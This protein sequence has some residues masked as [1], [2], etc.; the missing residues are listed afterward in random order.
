ME[1]HRASH[2]VN[3]YALRDINLVIELRSR[4]KSRGFLNEWV[5]CWVS[6]GIRAT[7]QLLPQALDPVRMTMGSEGVMA[8]I[9]F[10]TLN[11]RRLRAIIFKDNKEH[12]RFRPRCL[13][14]WELQP[15]ATLH[16]KLLSLSIGSELK[17]YLFR[18]VFPNSLSSPLS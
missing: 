10:S 1:L 13:L 17:C 3:T 14:C 9:L 12:V 11:Q 7:K 18:G 6:C 15:P 2:G 16:L 4:S 5:F 8:A